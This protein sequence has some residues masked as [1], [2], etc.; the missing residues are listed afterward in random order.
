MI[1]PVVFGAIGF[2]LMNYCVMN[3]YLSRS[4][5]AGLL[6]L[7]I[8]LLHGGCQSG[9]PTKAD[10][11]ASEYE[12]YFS[13]YRLSGSFILYNLKEDRYFYVNPSQKDTLLT[14]AS[15]FKICNSLIGLET[16]VLE[17][18][19]TVIAWDSVERSAAS[20]NQDQTL[21]TAFRRSAVWYYQ[22]VAR[23]VGKDRMQAWIDKAEY[24]NRQIGG[25][26]DFF[27]LRGDLRIS[28]SQQIEFLKNLY[29]NTLPFSTENQ[30][31]VKRIMLVEETQQYVLRAKTGWAFKNKAGWYV[32]YVERDDNVYFFCTC[33]QGDDYNNDNFGRSRIEISRKILTDMGII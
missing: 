26:I 23:R 28:P 31:I 12:K 10:E 24:G 25:E 2:I 4:V 11:N 13:E 19:N 6:C 20:W 3:K 17:D 14:P 29:H 27:W 33:V 8:L 32:G 9:A 18:E 16:G 5:Q 1:T 30:E 22:E 7:L 15:T 21:A